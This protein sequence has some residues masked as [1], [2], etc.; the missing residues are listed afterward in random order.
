MGGAKNPGGVMRR[1]RHLLWIL[2]LAA[3]AAAP[4]YATSVTVL[5]S[6]EWFQV[7][8]NAGVT[9]GSITTEGAFTVSLS[10]DDATSDSDPDPS[11]GFYLLLA[12]TT[13]L[14]LSTGSYT[15]SLSS[16]E[17]VELGVD[18]NWSGQDDFGLFAENFSTSGP[19]PVG[20]TTGYGY[21]NP[22]VIDSTQTAHSSDSLTDLP[23]AVSAYDSPNLGMYFLIAVNGAGTNK[24][25]ELFGEF[26]EFTVLPE[27]AASFLL[28]AGC[29][30]LTIARS[31]RG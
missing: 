11:V 23:W 9:D 10:F 7:T 20:V 29:G 5:L 27:P 15:F 4:A 16:S 14:S 22:F 17:N 18:D 31:R 6:G 8:D 30:A 28:L 19:L 26:T 2:A 3:L 21:M 24:F 25:I 12:P 1:A 13:D